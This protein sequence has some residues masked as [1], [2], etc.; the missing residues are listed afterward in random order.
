MRQDVGAAEAAKTGL[1]YFDAWAHELVET[2]YLHNHAHRW[3][4]SIW[5]FTLGLPWR[6]AA[7]FFLR[8]S[9]DGGPASN[10]LSW[11][12][13]SG[14]H[15]RGKPYHA[16]DWNIA[17]FTNHRFQPRRGDLADVVEG[18]KAQEPD[19]LPTVQRLRTPNPPKPKIPSLLLITAD[20]CRPEDLDLDRYYIVGNLTLASSHLRSPQ[21]VS[22]A[23]QEFEAG[24]LADTAARQQY[25]HQLLRASV[26][27]DLAR[28]AEGAGAKQIITA[29]IPEGY[30]RDWINE[31]APP[32]DAAGISFTELRRPWDELI[33]PHA[34]AGFFK[35]KKNIPNIL[36]NAG[37]L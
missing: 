20:D 25:P 5:T 7:D 34:T 30:L 17:K 10:T 2:G 11:R 35:V 8:H 23:V 24:A 19:G 18:L 32:L 16:Q 6:L 26:P 28:I 1:G 13:V 22:E 4:A 15:T 36:H 12:W 33:W 31:A 3:F 9:L 21:S 37:L 14:L 27:S 29:Y